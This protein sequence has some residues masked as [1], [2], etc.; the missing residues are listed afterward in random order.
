MSAGPAPGRPGADRPGADQLA[1]VHRRLVAA[2]C[3][4]TTSEG[5]ARMLAVAARFHSYSAHNIY[6]IAAQRPAATQVAGYRTWQSLGRQVGRGERG[7][8]IL[9]PVSYPRQSEDR[10][11][12]GAEAPGPTERAGRVLRGFR[13]A[14]VFDVAQTSGPPLPEVRPRLL[15]G[16]APG[17]LWEHLAAQVAAA[18]YTLGRADTAPANGCTDQ[19]ARHVRVHEGLPPAQAVKTLAHELAH[20]LLHAPEAGVAVPRAVAEIESESVAYLVTAAA[21]LESEDYSVPYLAGWSGGDPALVA[22]AAGR[23]LDAAR[24]ILHRAGIADGRGESAEAPA[25][26]NLPARANLQSRA[27]R[28]SRRGAG[29]A[30]GREL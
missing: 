14:H 5:W 19:L 9:A 8:A 28:Q 26:E 25:R 15:V 29:R 24:A 23:V 30:A 4:L 13:V 2:T 6:L 12:P 3:E 22:A 20:V 1:E 27:S 10:E 17:E 7:I 16:D 11:R 21:G 18:G